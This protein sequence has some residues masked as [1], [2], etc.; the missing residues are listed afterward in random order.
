[1]A[2][3]AP[4]TEKSLYLGDY[5]YRN[6]TTHL[7]EIDRVRNGIAENRDGLRSI[8]DITDDQTQLNRRLAREGMQREQALER[9]NGVANFQD[10]AILRK[11][12]RFSNS[13]CRLVTTGSRGI[14]GYG[15]GCLVAPN[16][17]ITNNHVL[18]DADTATRTV[19]Q[20]SYEL[21][22]QNRFLEPITFHLRPNQFFL[23]STFKADPN[24]PFSGLDF[25]LV[26]VE[27]TS[28][29][30]GSLDT[31][32]FV[33]LDPK[34]GKIIEGEYCVVI[35]HPKGDYKKIVLKDIRLLTLTDNFLIY[36]SDTQPGSSGSLVLGLGTGEAVALHHSAIPRKDPAGNWLRRDGTPLRPGDGD[37]MVDWLGN[38]GIRVSRIVEA[39][40][41]LP[42]PVSMQS[43]RA[44]IIEAQNATIII[45]TRPPITMTPTLNSP[46]IEFAGAAVSA[47]R[48]LVQPKLAQPE[49]SAVYHF[50]VVL[51]DLP[52]MQ[53]DW[54]DKAANLIPGLVNDAPMLPGTVVPALRRMRYIAVQTN[55]HPWLVAAEI[56]NLPHVETCRPDLETYT[57]VGLTDP[58][59]ESRLTESAIFN[60]GTA[61][62]NETE[63]IAKWSTKKWVVEAKKSGNDAIKGRQQ[64][65]WNWFA[66][67]CPVGDPLANLTDADRIKLLTNLPQLQMVQMDTGYSDHSKV[68]GGYNLD[69]DHDAISVDHDARDEE[70][71]FFF[72]FPGHGTRTASLV[73]GGLF[74][75]EHDGNGGLLVRNG[76][77]I[78]RLIPYRVAQSVILIGRGKQVVEAANVAMRGG[79]NVLYMCMGTYP[80]PM[81]DAIARE[82]YER[83]V[84]W[85]C[86][87][88]NEVGLVIAPALYPGII[89]VAAINPDD[90]PW[91]KSSKGKE[92]DISA[93]GEDVYV[94]FV[95][96]DEKEIMVYGSGT[97]YATP[98][99]ASAALLWRAR[100]ADELKAYLPWQIVEA[101]RQALKSSARP[102]SNVP[103]NLYGAGVLD[104]GKLL[105]TPPLA[106]TSPKM[107]HAYANIAPRRPSDLGI[108]EAAH[109]FW[110]LLRRKRRPDSVESLVGDFPLTE[111]AQQAMAAFVKP[112]LSPAART[113]SGMET[114]DSD[115]LLR[116][117][118]NQ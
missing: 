80:R 71:R 52:T 4:L 68:L 6:Y 72:K 26:A 34:L 81:L 118:F 22:D 23:T 5:A 76:K 109:F 21:G 28:A 15:T 36:E 53:D 30:G 62:P 66:I 9:V 47:Q 101:F 99:V 79:A 91:D 97:S 49:L 29:G 95:D 37:D 70:A 105:K 16:V 108:A 54:E 31:F 69:R 58:S 92:V 24:A 48:E 87:A 65:W 89:A 1:M 50:E 20:F 56:E 38:E 96:K 44:K 51:S 14:M 17:L 115:A 33:Q 64:R 113:E 10:I 94:P 90:R 57:D 98:H 11:I 102:F 61:K 111:R 75:S 83:G 55:R 8:T 116:Q 32:G 88:G 13:V 3:S 117:Y 63:F 67:N 77:P 7:Q 85:V 93:P 73:I 74:A 84:I 104:I 46:R 27:P 12:L 25:T 100:Y 114:I 18:P 42:V 35:Q 107:I 78:S 39:F 59:S 112:N 2:P 45:P 86:A 110:N 106:P 103:E 19:A 41:K 43:A 60:D 40:N 82:A